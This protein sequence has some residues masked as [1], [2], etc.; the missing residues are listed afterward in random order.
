M[1]PANLA[2]TVLSAARAVFETRGLDVAL[3]PVTTTVERP[4]NPEHGD[5]A[6]NLALQLGKKAGVAPRELAA[7]LAEELGRRDGI[8]AVEIAGPGFL[9]IRLDTASLGAI[10]GLVVETGSAYGRNTALAG[11]KV[12]LE[13]VSANP[14]G[15]IHLGH[16]R[17]AA[18]GD[19]LRRVLSAA[20]AEVTSE[21]YINDAGAQVER[22][23]RSLFAAANGEPA[24]EDG[25]VGDYITEIARTITDADPALIGQ[26]AEV[27]LPVFQERGY[28]LMLAEIR[29]SL[30]RFGVYFD[31]WFS[32]QTLHNGGAVEHAL[33]ELRKQGHIFEEGGAIWL[34]TTD[35]T[36]DKDRVLIRSNGEK[37]YFA[38]DA[39]YYINKRERGFDRCIYLLGADH[40]GYIGRLKAIAACAGDDPKKNIEILIGQLVNLVRAGQPVRLSK[41]AGNIITLDEL[42]EAVGADAAR[43]S[44]ARS[45]TDST[46][47]LDIEEITKNSSDNPVFYVQYA[48]ARICSLLRNA[49]EKKVSRGEKYDPALLSHERERNLLKTLGE[50]PGVVATAAE[51]RE[52]HRIAVYLE[53]RVATDYHRFYDACQVLPKG[54]EPVSEFAQSRLWLAEATRTVLAN[55][56]D[57]LGV[58]APERM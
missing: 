56:L 24:P 52:P 47:T 54:D 9:N 14:T 38:A 27:A 22:F 12:N 41:R 6:S 2:D 15:P 37:T 10:A 50:F 30:E 45:S 46:L 4:R 35:F 49:E 11:E 32:E 26:P 16:T 44:L 36:D 23:A 51:L 39:A 58:S 1:T 28:E 29:E 33:D 40:H 42:V 17:W 34:R 13:F 18:V 57:L 43:Y 48:H 55:G 20:G 8:S 7:A 25:Y 53:E 21:Y 3:L 5:Y 31:V 19:S